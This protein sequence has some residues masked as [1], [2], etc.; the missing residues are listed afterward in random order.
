MRCFGQI[1]TALPTRGIALVTWYRTIRLATAL[2]CFCGVGPWRCR[3]PTP[4]DHTAVPRSLP[5]HR[6][7]PAVGPLSAVRT[8]LCVPT[9]LSR[10]IGIFLHFLPMHVYKHKL[11]R[12]KYIFL[13]SFPKAKL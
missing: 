1:D 5:C 13:N 9:F 7:G 11:F 12:K 3:P 4:S 6:N 8:A 10:G 2:P